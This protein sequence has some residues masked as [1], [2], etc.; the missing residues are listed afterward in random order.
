MKVSNMLL[1]YKNS[2][3]GSNCGRF[4]IFHPFYCKSLKKLKSHNAEK[5]KGG[6]FSLARYCMLRGKKEKRFWFSSLGQKVQFGALKFCR[7]LVE[8]F[9]SFQVDRKKTLSKSH[10]NSRLFS[11]KAPTKKRLY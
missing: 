8:L 1:E 3:V 4:A 6:T 10:E 7:F 9:W 11:R 5:M 2:K